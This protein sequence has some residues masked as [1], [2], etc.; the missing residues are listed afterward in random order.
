MATP[1]SKWL[2]TFSGRQFWPLD[3]RAE[4]VEIADIAHALANQCR[5]TGHTKKFFSVAQHS[6]LVS[7]VVE[8]LAHEAGQHPGYV[9]MAAFW[10]LLHDASEAY[11]IDFARPLK[12]SPGIGEQYRLVE[13]QVQKAICDRFLLPHAMPEEV[14]EADDRMLITE[15]RDLMPPSDLHPWP[16][17]QSEPLPFHIIPWVPAE[18]EAEFLLR[19]RHLLPEGRPEV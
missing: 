16:G 14:R 11:L 12:H 3:P 19:F 8:R 7:S 15:W 10:G 18:A 5:W 1:T 13:T 17:I 6:I 9:R 2:Q 4:D